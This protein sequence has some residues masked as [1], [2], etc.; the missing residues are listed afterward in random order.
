MIAQVAQPPVTITP[1]AAAQP[2]AAPSLPPAP[3]SLAE[4]FAD[5]DLASTRPALAATPSGGA[6]DLTRIEIPREAK[7]APPPPPAPKAKPAPPPPP[8]EPSRIWVQVATGK[9]RSALAFDWKRISKK[10]SAELA[11][12]GPFVASWGQATRLL[13][14][15]YASDDAARAAVRKLKDMGLDAFTFTSAAGE[16]VEPLK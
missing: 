13:A 15:P 10:A 3:E 5:F 16:K 14:G 7:P 6:V 9:D 2:E 8:K 11:R 4:A 12:K 1:I